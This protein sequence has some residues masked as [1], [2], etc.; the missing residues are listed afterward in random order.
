MLETRFSNIRTEDLIT[1]KDKPTV[2]EQREIIVC[3]IRSYKQTA[4][5]TVK[6]D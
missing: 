4:I 5:V 1:Y 3:V 2:R 6:N